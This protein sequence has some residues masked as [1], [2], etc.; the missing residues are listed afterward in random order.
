SSQG[1]GSVSEE[2]AA[3]FGIVPGGRF[4]GESCQHARREG[5]SEARRLRPSKKG[6][7]KIIGL[8]G[9]IQ[10]GDSRGQFRRQEAHT[11]RNQGGSRLRKYLGVTSQL[12]NMALNE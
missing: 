2:H 1:V 9:P 6:L 8:W 7:S 4:G 11:Q 10:Q 3:Q 12:I 5:S